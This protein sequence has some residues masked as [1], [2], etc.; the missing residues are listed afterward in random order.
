MLSASSIQRD[1]LPSQANRSARASKV[2]SAIANQSE[3]NRRLWKIVNGL[4]L[5]RR[6]L[7]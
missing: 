1:L 6:R 7:I 5:G 3:A 4:L 2:T